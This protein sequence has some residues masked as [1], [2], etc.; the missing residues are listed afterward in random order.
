LIILVE[1]HFSLS[2]NL[3]FLAFN[4]MLIR[5]VL[6]FEYFKLILQLINFELQTVIFIRKRNPSV[7]KIA[8]PNSFIIILFILI[9]I[10]IFIQLTITILPFK[11][12]KD[13][14]MQH[15]IVLILV[16]SVFPSLHP[17]T[18]TH[19]PK[20]SRRH[21]SKNNKIGG[22]SVHLGYS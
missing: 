11:H 1:Y 8:N 18:T 22:Y 2:D 12:Y 9:D 15:I 4:D 6:I 19:S 7:N 21:A 16:I 3:L 5:L 13:Y 20:H 14:Y 17:A 10:L